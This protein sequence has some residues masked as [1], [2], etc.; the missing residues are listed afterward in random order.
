MLAAITCHFNPIEYDNIVRNYWMFREDLQNVDLFT[1]ELSFTDKFEVNDAT[2][3]QAQPAQIMWQKER[4]LN[5]LVEKLPAKYDK[6]ARLDGDILFQNANWAEAAEKKLDEFP[7][8]QLFEFAYDTDSG[9]DLV[10]RTP[11]IVRGGL[12]PTEAKPGYA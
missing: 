12:N 8:V 10:K 4:L 3:L 5:I 6:I 1:I 11:G 7:L 9:L 2:Q